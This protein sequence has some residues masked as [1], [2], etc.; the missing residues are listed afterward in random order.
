MDA[1]AYGFAL[2]G[3]R[4]T[5]TAVR[6]Y[7]MCHAHGVNQEMLRGVRFDKLF[8]DIGKLLI[9]KRRIAH[10]PGIGNGIGL[11]MHRRHGLSVN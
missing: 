8:P 11:L 10:R 9:G 2:Y 7:G 6:P 1:V 5:C 4:K 3:R